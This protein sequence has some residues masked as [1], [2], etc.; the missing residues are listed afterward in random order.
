V[1]ISPGPFGEAA[2]LL[3]DLKLRFRIAWVLV[4]VLLTSLTE[5]IGL[6]LLVPLLASISG[7]GIPPLLGG[8]LAGLH[9]PIELGPLLLVFV[10]VVLLRAVI[11]YTRVINGDK[12]SFAV[13][14]GLRIETLQ[15]LLGADWRTLSAMRQSDNVNLLLTNPD[16]IR[17]AFDQIIT[18]VAIMATLAATGLAA[19]A[20]SPRVA[21]VVMAA[22]VLVLIAYAGQRRRAVSLG[23]ALGEAYETLFALV[24][25]NLGALRL[26]KSLHGEARVENELRRTI[27]Q[28]RAAELS[29]TRSAQIGQ[30]TLQVLSSVALALAVWIAVVQFGLA[31]TVLL[32]LVAL[33][34]RAMPLLSAL[35][36]CWQNWLHGVPALR[37]TLALKERL[38][39]AQEHAPLASAP[40][41]RLDRAIEIEG[42]RF[43]HE[44]SDR[45]ALSDVSLTLPARSFTALVGPSGAGKSTLADIV[46]GLISPD[47]GTVTVD[48]A[49]I[50]GPMRRSWRE[51]VAYVQQEPLLFHATIAENLRWA[52]PD[53]TAEAM[54]TALESASAQFVMGFEHGLETVVGDRGGRLSGGERQR[55]ALARALL[56]NPALLILDEPTSSL[57]SASEAA[58]CTA[59][60]QLKGRITILLIAHRGSLTALADQIVTLDCGRIVDRLDTTSDN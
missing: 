2:W 27:R 44:G 34:A 26:I 51:S 8:A 18:G 59:I 37:E 28:Q 43:S 23:E 29:F 38:L 5:G 32:P 31:A 21:L 47:A 57:D 4:L 33:F 39:A 10:G 56:R 20:L 45:P 55:I 58:I 25:E 22:G 48:G 15:L 54:Q 60:E 12:L 11:Q 53:A 35:Q 50:S 7:G 14:D 24:G 49:S 52:K 3:R 46:G 41:S 36:Q 42:V 30:A 40:A 16:R 6:V 17:F 13:A 1:S 19:F 9:L